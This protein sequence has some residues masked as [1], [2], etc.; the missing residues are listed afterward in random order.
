MTI[1]VYVC[2]AMNLLTVLGHMGYVNRAKL[3]EWMWRLQKLWRFFL[4]R[5]LWEESAAPH[6]GTWGQLLR[7]QTQRCENLFLMSQSPSELGT[8]RIYSTDKEKV[9]PFEI[10]PVLSNRH[11]GNRQ[12]WRLTLKSNDK[13]EW[14][15]WFWAWLSY[16]FSKRLFLHLNWMKRNFFQKL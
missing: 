1:C 15:W 16:E 2:S 11:L 14:W 7:S 3:K 13:E 9:R 4:P 8:Q 5:P 6:P 12:N 10:T